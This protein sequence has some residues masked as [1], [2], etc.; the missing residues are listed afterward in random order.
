M[1][2]M[3]WAGY[4][5]MRIARLGIAAPGLQGM[6]WQRDLMMFTNQVALLYAGVQWLAGTTSITAPGLQAHLP[7]V[8]TG[9]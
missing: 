8:C 7:T 3:R 2:Y 1:S 9:S 6:S 5:L 4:C